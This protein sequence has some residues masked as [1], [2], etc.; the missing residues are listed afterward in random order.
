MPTQ[1]ELRLKDIDNLDAAIT[2]ARD[3]LRIYKGNLTTQMSALTLAQS[4]TPTFSPQ[5]P[6]SRSPSP[7][8]STFPHRQNR[9]S[10]PQRRSSLKQSSNFQGFN[11]YPGH[12]QNFRQFCSR[13]RSQSRPRF[14]PRPFNRGRPFNRNQNFRNQ[15]VLTCH[16]CGKRG[17]YANE[18]FKRSANLSRRFPR[19]N[20]FRNSRP[21]RRQVRFFDG[22]RRFN[23]RQEA[24]DNS[25]Y[26][27]DL[28]S[29]GNP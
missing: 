26:E 17:H 12:D 22:N 16:Y 20:Q 29:Q 10:R 9:Q 8:S 13:S 18:C 1:I 14:R 21:P 3:C 11:R 27:D 4:P 24:Q 19:N 6:Q 23:D 25:D 15:R 28:N 7:R 5:H 2:E